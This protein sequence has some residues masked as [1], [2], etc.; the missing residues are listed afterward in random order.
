MK[1]KASKEIVLKYLKCHYEFGYF[2]N[3]QI[4][5]IKK[6]LKSFGYKIKTK[7]LKKY[8]EYFIKSGYVKTDIFYPNAYSL[9]EKMQEDWVYNPGCNLPGM[10]NE[11]HNLFQKNTK[12]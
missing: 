3:I 2:F 4:K 11:I 6:I 12:N 8:F 7:K 10:P 9:T 5:E 1:I